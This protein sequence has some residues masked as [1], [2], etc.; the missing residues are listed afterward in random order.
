MIARCLSARAQQRPAA[1]RS[2]SRNA[3][4]AAPVAVK[5]Q[6]R[7]VTVRSGVEH[8]LLEPALACSQQQSM[9]K[10]PRCFHNNIIIH[11]GSC[12]STHAAS[13]T[14]SSNPPTV[15][16]CCSH[17]SAVCAPLHASAD[18]SLV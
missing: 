17:S 4:Q 10:G 2:S 16:A 12:C 1:A 6:R 13:A 5:Q 9:L 8:L 3:V 11:S 18:I 14:Q 7:L 15:A